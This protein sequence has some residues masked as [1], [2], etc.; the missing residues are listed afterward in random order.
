MVLLFAIEVL[1]LYLGYL[2]C[3]KMPP[4]MR[5]HGRP[6]GLEKTVIGRDRKRQHFIKLP[7]VHRPA[8]VKIMVY[9]LL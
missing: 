7:D 2:N 5:K 8:E 6:K 3:I 1:L 9:L 4:T